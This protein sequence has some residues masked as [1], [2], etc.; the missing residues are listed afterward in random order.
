MLKCLLNAAH[1][2]WKNKIHHPQKPNQ[3][4]IHITLQPTKGVIFWMGFTGDVFY[5]WKPQDGILRNGLYPMSS[6]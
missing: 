6:P 1:I 2:M 5:F 4:I 3:N